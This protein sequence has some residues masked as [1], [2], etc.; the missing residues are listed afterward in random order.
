MTTRLHKYFH[1]YQA[2]HLHPV[3][4]LIHKIAIPLIVF[5]IIAMLSWLKLFTIYNFEISLAH[6]VSV[7]VLIFYFSLD[8]LYAIF[9]CF[10]IILCLFVSNFTSVWIVWCIA[11]IA[12]IL[13]F[14][15]H[16]FFEK[17]SPA[18]SKNFIQLLIGPLYILNELF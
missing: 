4:L 10:F 7:G 16:Y 15:G 11:F 3:N 17:K 8:I 13:Q 18:F 9:M 14:I 6:L 5:H 1:E 12:W 2:V